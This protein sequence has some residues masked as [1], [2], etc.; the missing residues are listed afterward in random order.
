MKISDL[1]YPLLI[2]LIS[3]LLLVI[4]FFA[5]VYSYL[6]PVSCFAI[7]FGIPT[8]YVAQHR[9]KTNKWSLLFVIIISLKITSGILTKSHSNSYFYFNRGLSFLI[10]S[11]VVFRLLVTISRIYNSYKKNKSNWGGSD[12]LE[13]LTRSFDQSFSSV[14]IAGIFASEVASVCYAFFLWKIPPNDQ[15]FTYHKKGPIKMFLYVL[16]F[17]FF[18]ETA[19]LHFVLVHFELKKLATILSL[20]SIYTMIFLIGQIKSMRLRPITLED[21]ILTIRYGLVATVPIEMSEIK[22]VGT[23]KRILHP[24]DK[25]SLKLSL[26]KNLEQQNIRIDLNE[27]ISVKMLFKTRKDIKH[28][29]FR[30]D[31]PEKLVQNIKFTNKDTVA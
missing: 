25:S 24:I 5:P 2:L 3:S 13:N 15:N 23:I 18:V 28:L 20:L 9:A 31:E 17:L 12:F 4:Y 1:R 8:A 14:K 29:Y 26:F 7:A 30:V 22:S 10:I 6:L 27:P 16:I 19:A 11:L 21:G